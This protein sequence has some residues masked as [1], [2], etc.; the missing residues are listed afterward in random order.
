LEEQREVLIELIYTTGRSVKVI[1]IDPNTGTEVVMVGDK[2]QSE[3]VLKHLAA[4]KLH[5]VLNK[6]S[7]KNRK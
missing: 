3:E 7:A 1:A 4:R 6:K 5:Y 2:N